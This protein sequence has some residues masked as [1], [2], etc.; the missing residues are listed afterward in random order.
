M[1]K[2]WIDNFT[3]YAV[4]NKQEASENKN[5]TNCY[6]AQHDARHS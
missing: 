6:F 1:T 4:S 5:S 2:S 3:R